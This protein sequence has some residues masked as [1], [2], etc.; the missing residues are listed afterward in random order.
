M[1]HQKTT[2]YLCAHKLRKPV[3]LCDKAQ[4]EGRKCDAIEIAEKR[5]ERDLCPDCAREYAQVRYSLPQ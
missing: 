4:R 1:C 3:K 5:K 2:V